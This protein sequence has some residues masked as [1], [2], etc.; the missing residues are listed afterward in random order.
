M[1]DPDIAD[2]G[3]V[4]LV[5]EPMLDIDQRCRAASDGYSGPRPSHAMGGN[6]VG[7]HPDLA[8]PRLDEVRQLFAAKRLA[9]SVAGGEEEIIRPLSLNLNHCG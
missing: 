2:T 6:A 8:R 5:A 3:G 9:M 4:L 1:F 7:I